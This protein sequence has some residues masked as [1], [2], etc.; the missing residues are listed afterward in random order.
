MNSPQRALSPTV[1]LLT[2]LLVLL[3]PSPLANVALAQFI[4][5]SMSGVVQDAS[6]AGIPDAQVTLTQV[7]TG[8]QRTTVTGSSGTFVYTAL[9][10]GEYFLT[11]A[12]NGFKTAEKKN[13]V[14]ETGQRYPAGTI[15]LEVGTLSEV[16][17]VSAKSAVVETQSGER[18][19]SISTSQLQNL[20]NMGRDF[21]TL[22]ALVPG[23]VNQTNPG[24]PGARVNFNALG[25]RNTTNNITVDGTPITSPDYPAEHSVNLSQDSIEELKILTSNYQA[26]YGRLSG[27]NME[28]VIKSGTK[29]FHG[30]G[31]YF[32]RH[33][34]FNAM[35][36][37]DNRDGR[38]KPRYR[39]STWTYNLGGPIYIPGKFNTDKS[40]LFFFFNQEFWPSKGASIQRVN[41]P[42]ELERQGDF[43]RSFDLNRKLITVRDPVTKQPYQGNKIPQSQLDASGLALL[44]AFPQPNF[45]DRNISG[46]NYNFVSTFPTTSMVRYDTV[47]IDYNINSSNFLAVSYTGTRGSSTGTGRANWPQLP[48][49]GSSLDQTYSLRYTHVFSPTI[50]NEFHF[51]WT[52]SYF[53]TKSPEDALARNQRDTAGFTAGQ[54]FPE[55][56]PLN[57]LPWANFGAAGTPG[58]VPGTP[59]NL[60]YLDRYPFT[61]YLKNNLISDR[62][63]IIR[64]SH[65]LKFGISFERNSREMGTQG[66][67]AFG[68]LDFISNPNNPL[69]TGYPYANAAAGVFNSYTESSARP[70]TIALSGITEAFAQDTWRVT[71]RLTLDLGARISYF[72]PMY[73]KNDLLSG[74][75]PWTYDPS[76]AVQLIQPGRN[77]SGKR[78]GIN[79]VNGQEYPA[80]AIGAI[81]EGSGNTF[82]GLVVA[83]Q[84]GVPRALTSTQGFRVAPRFGFAYDVFGNGKTAI[85]GGFGIFFNRDSM[86]STYKP[87]SGLPPNVVT[88]TVQYGTLSTLLSSSSLLFPNNVSGRFLSESIPHAM[89][90]SLAV[91]Q[92]IG[93][94]TVLDIAYV[95]ALGQN[96]YWRRDINPVPAGANFQPD[97]MDPTTNTALPAA[98]LR[99]ITGYGSI[100]M[101]EPGASS[102]YH[103]LQV[104]ARR[105]FTR[106]L[107]FGLAW[108]YS[109]AMDYVDNDTQGPNPLIPIREWDYGFSGFDRTHVVKIN[110]VYE[111]P[112]LTN[113]YRLVRGALNG[114]QAAG[115]LTFQS[116]APMTVT[117]SRTSAID[118]TGTPSLNARVDVIGDPTLPAD[119]RTFNQAFRTDVFRLPEVGTFGNAGRWLFRGPGVNN[120][121]LS[122][123]KNFRIAERVNSQ[124]RIEMYN[125]FNHTQFTNINTAARFD[126]AG[127]QVN[128]QFGQYSTAAP[129]RIMQLA[130][131]FAF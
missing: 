131:R 126:T 24:Q 55:A 27:A 10:A 97:N 74:F 99:P 39:Y 30:L 92:D 117:W 38:A 72:V 85:R 89:N 82:N 7:T 9:E 64:G 119:E 22:V 63:S 130:L 36:F 45:F 120:W 51:G 108:T 104:S 17:S 60:N 44:N 107:E 25:M 102:N 125:A 116:G 20:S 124:F 87:F 98:F 106:G 129:A 62:L 47:K 52:Q 103:S 43:S 49:N 77:A 19:L 13:V 11:V 78:V 95:G 35:N 57:L 70:W 105:R 23:V 26:E 48:E 114:W 90:F 58:G 5:S 76:N 29:D 16:I 88:P 128:T 21:K 73:D 18:S 1:F 40:K 3:L 84:N 2:M 91:Q 113:G 50:L 12:K 32:K 94:S 68:S 71:K 4:T 111:L 59:A 109:K 31:S 123:M 46:G 34:Q 28:V 61:S 56:N 81:A 86:D 101:I 42:T 8:Q 79:P 37:F 33:E 93:L 96:L 83:G 6:G 121:D 54:L 112:K 69:D 53:D 67:F 15:V 65:N 80:A 75:Q 41:V 127:N 118:I 66:G 110:F 14:L 100:F 122:V 115:I